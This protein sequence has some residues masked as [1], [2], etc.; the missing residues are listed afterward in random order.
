MKKMK[1]ILSIV[2]GATLLGSAFSAFAVTSVPS[3]WYVEGNTGFANLNNSNFGSG[4]SASSSVSWWGWNANGGFKFM[5]YFA[6]E[7]GL[8]KYPTTTIRTNSVNIG[9]SSN[10]S[11][12]LAGKGILP[13]G[14]S[15]FEFFAK[16]GLARLYSHVT[17]TNA[18]YTNANN[19][20]LNTGSRTVTGAYLGA[21]A[22]YNFMPNLGVLLQW[23]RAKG[24]SI[25]GN[26]DLYTLGLNYNFG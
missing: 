17:N 12:D 18:A 14:D 16:L 6:T 3:G 21:G 23:Q 25:T 9:Q 7:F 11:Y 19:V 20:S 22:D 8:S 26:E 24:N 1:R 13:V 15:G 10:W 4:T 5:P 2:V